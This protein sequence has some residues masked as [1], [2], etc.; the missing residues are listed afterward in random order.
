MYFVLIEMATI[1]TL[2]FLFEEKFLTTILVGIN[3]FPVMGGFYEVKKYPGGGPSI[4][5]LNTT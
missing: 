4:L 5:F 1:N 3:L 2:F